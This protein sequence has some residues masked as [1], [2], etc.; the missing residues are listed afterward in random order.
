MEINHSNFGIINT[1]NIINLKSSNDNYILSDSRPVV[2][3]I[4]NSTELTY[5]SS[6]YDKLGISYESL[7][8][9]LL[10]DDDF[11]IT[12]SKTISRNDYTPPCI[13]ILTINVN[14]RIIVNDGKCTCIYFDFFR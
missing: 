11:I 13:N 7:V 8:I 12:K 4:N 5:F 6:R 3:D 2:F 1:Q 14:N 9:N 10:G